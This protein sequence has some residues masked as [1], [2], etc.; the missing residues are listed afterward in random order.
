MSRNPMASAEFHRTRQKRAEELCDVLLRAI[1]EI[2]KLSRSHAASG[3]ADAALH[4]Y[5][6]I[7]ARHF[8]EDARAE[9]EFQAGQAADA[10]R[11]E[12]ALV[13]GLS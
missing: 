10:R 6:E 1:E 8:Q 4:R 3:I 13:E 11:E 12:R 9:A 2:S 7:S 5:D